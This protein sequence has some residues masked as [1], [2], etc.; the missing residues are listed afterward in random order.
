MALALQPQPVL[1]IG[2]KSIAGAL[3]V[4]VP[5]AHRLL[6]AGRLPAYK[7][8]GQHWVSTR[9]S[10]ESWAEEEIARRARLP[11]PAASGEDAVN[12]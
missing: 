1:I 2:I 9:A 6:K 11:V 12:T 4:G 8:E 3:G 7:L 10:L 5:M